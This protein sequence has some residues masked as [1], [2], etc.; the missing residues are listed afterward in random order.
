MLVK[1]QGR[2]NLIDSA[3]NRVEFSHETS[4]LYLLSSLFLQNQTC[5]PQYFGNFD[6]NFL[7][8][9]IVLLQNSKFEDWSLQSNGFKKLNCG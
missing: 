4:C 7:A 8:K 6:M 2:A 3:S 1:K 9:A 5:V